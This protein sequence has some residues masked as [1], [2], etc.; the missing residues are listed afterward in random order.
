MVQQVKDPVLSLQWCRFSPWLGTS[1]C[2]KAQPKGIKCWQK[3]FSSFDYTLSLKNYA[4]RKET[5]KAHMTC[6]AFYISLNPDNN[7]KV[8]NHYS[9]G[10]GKI[11]SSHKETL[12][13]RDRLYAGAVWLQNLCCFHYNMLTLF[14]K[15]E[16]VEILL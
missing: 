14:Y 7:L 3:Y 12:K 16:F 8:W 10:L 11:S 6:E 5:N 2:L 1:T 4:W 15:V 13:Y 9:W